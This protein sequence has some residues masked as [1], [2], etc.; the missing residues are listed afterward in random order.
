VR[1]E[2]VDGDRQ[3]EEHCDRQEQPGGDLQNEFQ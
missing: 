2:L 1:P 3:D